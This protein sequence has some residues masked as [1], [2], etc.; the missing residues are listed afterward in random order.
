MN[1]SSE[2]LVT[3][4]ALLFQTQLVYRYVTVGC[5]SA[6]PAFNASAAPR[7]PAPKLYD[8]DTIRSSVSASKALVEAVVGAL[9]NC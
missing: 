3:K 7:L 6:P 5:A 2:K 9:Y 4:F 1:L 8:Y